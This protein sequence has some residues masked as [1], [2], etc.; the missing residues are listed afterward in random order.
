M[1]GFEGSLR[2][3]SLYGQRTYAGH[4]WGGAAHG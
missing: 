3:G 1:G 2:W 4:G